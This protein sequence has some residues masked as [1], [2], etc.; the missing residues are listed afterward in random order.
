V[1]P[2]GGPKIGP[3]PAKKLLPGEPSSSRAWRFGGSA[4]AVTVFLYIRRG[5]GIQGALTGRVRCMSRRWWRRQQVARLA[6]VRKSH[7]ISPR[8][9]TERAPAPP[10]AGDS[11]AARGRGLWPRLHAATP[12]SGGK[13]PA[14][15]MSLVTRRNNYARVAHVPRMIC[16]GPDLDRSLAA[17][18]ALCCGSSAVMMRGATLFTSGTSGFR[19]AQVNRRPCANL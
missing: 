5:C 4:R 11:R 18:V 6:A 9:R 3:E 19:D 17:S 15:S 1:P 2:S 13:W 14:Q 7:D 16:S 10:A 12:C 8:E